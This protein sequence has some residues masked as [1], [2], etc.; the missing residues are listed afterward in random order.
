MPF[1]LKSR[2]GVAITFSFFG[3]S[4][5]VCDFMRQASHKTRAYI[6]NAKGLPGFLVKPTIIETL[7]VAENAGKLDHVTK[8]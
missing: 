8:W 3:D 2:N 1:A 5:E 4:T 6:V 7:R